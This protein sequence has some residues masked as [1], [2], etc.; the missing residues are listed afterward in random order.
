MKLLFFQS[1]IFLVFLNQYKTYKKDGSG[2][3]IW[4]A[5]DTYGSK[6]YNCINGNCLEVDGDY[7][8]FKTYNECTNHCNTITSRGALPTQRSLPPNTS[9]SNIRKIIDDA[10][11]NHEK[12][13]FEN[14]TYEIIQNYKPSRETKTDFYLKARELD[15]GKEQEFKISYKKPSFS[16]V[17]NKI[18]PKNVTSSSCLPRFVP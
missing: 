14:K 17:E 5:N 15:D 3:L 8:A 16:F 1:Y 10:K 12:F 2:I 4:K 7:G 13:A 6:S 9:E 11:N 18:K